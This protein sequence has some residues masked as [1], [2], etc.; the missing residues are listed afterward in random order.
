MKAKKLLLYI[1]CAV[2]ALSG[3]ACGKTPS[4]NGN[5]VEEKPAIPSTG[6]YIFKDG[7]S[8]YRIVIPAEAAEYELYAADELQYFLELS[9]GKEIEV[10]TDEEVSY[11]AE[12]EFLALGE[13]SFRAS[14]GAQYTAELGDSGFRIDTKGNS[15]FMSGYGAEGTLYSVYDFLYYSA[16]YEFFA[17]D[18]I[19]INTT[20]DIELLAF[21]LKSVPALQRRSLGYKPLWNSVS[22]TRRLRFVDFDQDYIINGHTFGTILPFETYVKDHPEWFADSA[23]KHSQPCLTNPDVFAEFVKNSKQIIR[24]HPDGRY[25]MLG[26]NDN[27]KFC[28][29]RDCTDA[30]DKYY[31]IS[32]VLIDFVN[33]VAAALDTWLAAEY[34]G[35]SL[36][37][38]TYAYLESLEAPVILNSVTGNY[39]AAHADVIPRDNVIV[40][41]TPLQADYTYSFSSSRNSSMKSLIDSWGSVTSNLFIYSYCVNFAQ[42]FVPHNNFN[43]LAENYRFAQ[44]YGIY[45]YYEQGANQSN[46]NGFMELKF[47]LTSKLMWEPELDPVELTENF[48]RQY[49]GPAYDAMREYYYSLRNW[50]AHLQEVFDPPFKVTL[51][52]DVVKEAYWPFDLLQNWERNIFNAAFEA[53]EYLKA[54]D[55]SLYQK[56]YDRANKELLTLKFLYISLYQA[57]FTASEVIA[58]ID[59]F[60]RDTALYQLNYYK[61][62]N[63]TKDLIADWRSRL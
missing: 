21:G 19:K 36:I 14:S 63:Y 53:I 59:D 8:D 12:A 56:Y 30:K 5:K 46:T 51:Y 35:R 6:R 50:Y 45:A 39:A 28:G 52:A 40:M 15:V 62:G 9:T 22:Y 34:P 4:E 57:E 43:I 47:Y 1:L 44:K 54:I 49:Y 3:C 41:I 29:C 37:Y 20:G 2:V 25:F 7:E 10:V 24:N 27:G 32:G 42:Y 61:E 17:G 48:L 38:T 16:G 13:V 58:L 23:N 26:Q 60:E 33:R 31:T 55:V 11:T 18:E